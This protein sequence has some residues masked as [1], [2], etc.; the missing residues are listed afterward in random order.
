[1]Q[2]LLQKTT[3]LALP[4]AG[5]LFGGCPHGLPHHRALSHGG[6]GAGEGG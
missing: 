5:L 4:L 1:M 3:L 6:S 2:T